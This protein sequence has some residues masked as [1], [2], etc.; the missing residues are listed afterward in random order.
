MQEKVVALSVGSL[1]NANGAPH[2]APGREQRRFGFRDH[3]AGSDVYF[4][5]MPFYMVDTKST[6]Y[7]GP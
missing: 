2:V 3:D 7:F 1:R 5:G 4:V 6:F